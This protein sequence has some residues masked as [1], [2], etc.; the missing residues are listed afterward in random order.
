MPE[1]NNQEKTYKQPGVGAIIGG[2]LVGSTVKGFVSAPHKLVAQKL[3][4]KMVDI[5]GNLTD[6]EFKTVEKAIQDTIETPEFA[7]KSVSMIKAA[8][9][10]ADKISEILSKEMNNNVLLKIFPEQIKKMAGEEYYST[11]KRGENAFYL[12]KEKTIIAPGRKLSLA[13]F[14]EVGHAANHNLSKIGKT[15]QKCKYLNILTFPISMIALW[16]T[17]KAPNQE[18]KS[19]ADKATTF[20]KEN[21]GKLTFATFIPVLLEEGL[22]SIKGN[23]F[24]KKALSPE[25]AKRVVK[26]NALGFLSYVGSA[27]FASLG[28]YIGTK[29]KDAIAKPKLVEKSNKISNS[30]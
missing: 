16:K 13:L 19:T 20:I 25:L 23:N 3:L 14:H 11:V 4:D 12:F 15:L 6:D 28:I 10:N 24:A 18:P 30:N 26:T 8:S 29:V 7:Q 9:E 17:K 27:A 22:A 2:V 21:A 5:S 1:I